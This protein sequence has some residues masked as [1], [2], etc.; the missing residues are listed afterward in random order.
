MRKAAVLPAS[1]IGDALLMMI[2]SEQ[3][4]L[5]GYSVTTFHNALPEL[6]DWFPHH[7]IQHSSHIHDL[8][9]YDLIIAEND[10]SEKIQELI[11]NYRS[12]L[13]I[14]YLTYKEGKHAPLT[15]L[16]C[17]FNADFPMAK[18]VGLAIGK[19]LH[20]TKISTDNGITPPLYLKNIP[21][22]QQV[23]IHPTSSHVKKN[24]RPSGFLK[25]A[26]LLKNQG[27]TAQFC[28]S[29]DEHNA[30]KWLSQRGF[31]VNCP[32]TLSD[33]AAEIFLSSYVIGNDSLA[34]HL[35]SNL[36]VPSC[37]IADGEKR[38]RLWRPGWHPG[39]LVLTP[40]WLPK[41]KFFKNRWAHFIFP[42]NV[43][44]TISIDL[45]RNEYSG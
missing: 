19:L 45:F 16:D 33:L 36:G 22:R 21:K 18:N 12:Q 5:N 11:H 42:N 37:V 10:N 40:Q 31:V 6:R 2:A 41:W 30:W 44:K 1:G 43:W 24:W 7:K 9:N 38:M 32:P 13:R 27:L 8:K 3:L 29:P 34:G 35:A 28:M 4:L 20:L 25:I 39:S 17:V 15:P 14:F 23:L 26:Q